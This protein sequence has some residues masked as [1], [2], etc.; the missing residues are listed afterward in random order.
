MGPR[1]CLSVVSVLI[2][3]TALFSRSAPPLRAQTSATPAQQGEFI[4]APSPQR[5]ARGRYIATAVAHCFGCHGD[6][7]FAN[8]AQPK[9]GTE[10]AGNLPQGESFNDVSAPGILP[11]P[12][13][14]PDKETGAGTWTDAQFERAIRHG[15]GHDGRILT[16]AMPYAFFRSMTD[17]DVA[18]VIVYLRSIAPV[19][20]ALPKTEIIFPVKYLMRSVPQPVTEPVPEPDRSNPTAY[21]KYLV[22]VAGCTDCHTPQSKG[23]SIPDMDF[24]GGFILEG[25]WGRV[26][27]DNITP[28]T[29]G[30]SYYDEALFIQTMR[31]G[32][33][34]ARELNQIMPW[35]HFRNLTDDDLRAMFAYLRTLKPVT[36][37]VD[38][39]EP[40]TFCKACRQTHGGGNQN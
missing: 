23:Q 40:P 27:G 1:S 17:E 37:R 16:S 2:L 18:S 24:A 39:T 5:L 29:S 21:G 10:G 13:L 9:P 8:D 4:A 20:K 7:D 25:P 32:Y 11:H 3:F 26:A 36:H 30:I 6:P 38:N 31:T 22:S 33:V 14:T 12:N 34:K 15:V 19:H 35:W 28:D